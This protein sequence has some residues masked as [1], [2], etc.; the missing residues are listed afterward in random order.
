MHSFHQDTSFSFLWSNKLH[1]QNFLHGYIS[2]DSG[3]SVRFWSPGSS[4]SFTLSTWNQPLQKDLFFLCMG[5]YMPYVHRFP[6]RP[7]EGVGSSEAGVTDSCELSS[8]A[9]GAKLRSSARAVGTINC[10]AIPSVPGS[11]LLT[12]RQLMD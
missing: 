4:V 11:D 2:R 7:E 6:W 10:R 5:E 3:N 9:A 8:M 1:K 12:H